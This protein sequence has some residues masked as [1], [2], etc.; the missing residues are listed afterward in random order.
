MLIDSM[1]ILLNYFD[2]CLSY[3]GFRGTVVD[4]AT[5]YGLYGSVFELQ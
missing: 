1:L 4:I 5:C 2:V 3:C